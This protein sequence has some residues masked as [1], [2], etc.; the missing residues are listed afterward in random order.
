[1]STMS[2]FPRL[3]GMDRFSKEG[4]SMIAFLLLLILFLSML[5]VSCSAPAEIPSPTIPPVTPTALPV[6]T[7]EMIYLKADRVIEALHDRDLDRLASMVHPMLGIRF[8]PYAFVRD[9]D[10]TVTAEDVPN[11]FSDNEVFLWGAYDGSGAPIELTFEQYFDQFIYDQDFAN[12]EE[13]GYNQRI[14]GEGGT[15]HNIPEFYPGGVFVEYHFRGFNPDYGGL[16]WRSLRL[17]FVQDGGE[18]FLVGII[19][20]EWTT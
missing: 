18:W 8:S 19:H 7:E 6:S 13:I 2:K 3:K 17:V 12:A 1:M 10:I 14:G 15:I 4:L 11:L 9:A 16:D 20:D 5:V